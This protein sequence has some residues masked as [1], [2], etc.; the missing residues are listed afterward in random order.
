MGGRRVKRPKRQT[1]AEQAYDEL[2]T[3]IMTGSLSPGQRLLPVELAE[4]MDVSQTPVKEALA[5]LERDGLV[6]GEARRASTVR[7]FNVRDVAEIYEARI[8]LELYAIEKIM[9]EKLATRAFISEMDHICDVL[10]ENVR[11]GTPE[12]LATAVLADSEFHELMVAQCG[13][14]LVTSWHRTVIRQFQ[15][16]RNFTFETYPAESTIAG[17]RAIVTA[18]RGGV[19]AD[20][21]AVLSF[22]LEGSRDEMLQRTGP[23]APKGRK[24]RSAPVE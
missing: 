16:A 5:A 24:R 14:R 20:G 17:H 21:L 11:K 8:L 10:A 3:R 23:D 1:L 15:T 13:N 19:I 4:E 6:E 18:I 12:G 9:R 22:H 2:Q 7:R